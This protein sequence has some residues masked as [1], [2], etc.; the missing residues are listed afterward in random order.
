MRWKIY[1]YISGRGSTAA[2][3]EHT[4]WFPLE[5][6]EEALACKAQWEAKCKGLYPWT[7]YPYFMVTI[8]KE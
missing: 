8:E 2:T 3:E 4:Y 6:T 5:R 7:E 1:V